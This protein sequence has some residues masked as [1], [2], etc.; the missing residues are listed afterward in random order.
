M[1]LK[2]KFTLKNVFVKTA[3][4]DTFFSTVEVS[5]S[6]LANWID[7]EAYA[8]SPLVR[9]ALWPAIWFLERKAREYAFARTGKLI[10]GVL[11]LLLFLNRLM[12]YETT[13]LCGWE[14]FVNH[15]GWGPRPLDPVCSGD[16]HL[17][18]PLPDQV[19][20]VVVSL[21][22]QLRVCECVQ[23]SSGRLYN[24]TFHSSTSPSTFFFNLHPLR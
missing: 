5:R 24:G 23:W 18:C 7:T 10:S 20:S 19:S 21:N 9:D 11:L 17:W 16:V 1:L 6:S 13:E 4:L 22:G 3:R 12:D 15:C 8:R 2:F 14:L